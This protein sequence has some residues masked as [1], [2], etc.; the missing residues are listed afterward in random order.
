M[1]EDDTLEIDLNSL[2]YEI[3]E[4]I[5]KEVAKKL[6]DVIAD[7]VKA[8]YLNE[9]VNKIVYGPLHDTF[10]SHLAMLTASKIS[11]EIAR[12]ITI[13]A[14]EKVIIK[15]GEAT[16]EINARKFLEGLRKRIEVILMNK[17]EDIIREA[18]REYCC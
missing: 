18:I 9:V 13:E 17:L 14:D 15:L 7:K 12:R 11:E 2:S 3:E 8:K 5:A 6:T 10:I 4:A 16:V 1:E